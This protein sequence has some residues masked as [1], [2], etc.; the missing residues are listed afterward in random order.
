M[1]FDRRSLLA[2][3]AA[4]PV[5][6]GLPWRSA[7]A[8]AANTVKIGV[9]IALSEVQVTEENLGAI[10]QEALNALV[11]ERLQAQEIANYPDLK[12]TDEEV[13]AQ[14]ADMA[15]QAGT[16]P[17]IY[18]QFLEQGGIR[19]ST[20][21]EYLRTSIGWRELV[22]GRFNGRARVSRAQVE[23]AMRQEAEAASK[24]RYRVG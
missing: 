2:A 15:Q 6:G 18:L 17:D 21:R 11:D 8:Q 1:A 19:A 13:N 9:L 10:Q 20:L 7:R 5:L 3:A 16:T 23:Q 22:G 24:K 12:I 4:A 14:I